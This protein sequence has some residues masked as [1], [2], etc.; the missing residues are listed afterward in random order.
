[1]TGGVRDAAS[2]NDWAKSGANGIELVVCRAHARASAPLTVS[3][4]TVPVPWADR[5]DGMTSPEPIGSRNMP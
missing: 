4:S 1:M 5:E 3:H 2:R